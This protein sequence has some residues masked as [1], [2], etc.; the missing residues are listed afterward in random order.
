MGKIDQSRACWNELG[1]CCCTGPCCSIPRRQYHEYLGT[2]CITLVALR[3]RSPCFSSLPLSIDPPAS[4]QHPRMYHCHAKFS[5]SA[6]ISKPVSTNP[7]LGA[8]CWY[9]FYDL[10]FYSG[11]RSPIISQSS[12]LMIMRAVNEVE[13]SREMYLLSVPIVVAVIVVISGRWESSEFSWLQLMFTWRLVL[14][15]LSESG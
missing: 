4:H 6:S 11:F 8:D 15:I 1:A 13:R 7:V 2:L 10:S 9:R 14:E 5:C 3:S 12:I